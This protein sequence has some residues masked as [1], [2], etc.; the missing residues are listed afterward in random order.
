M[1]QL[2]RTHTLHA[3]LA[4]GLIKRMMQQGD[5]AVL[6]TVLSG[7]ML[8]SMVQTSLMYQLTQLP[9]RER[10]ARPRATPIQ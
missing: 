4:N 6:R 5:M 8:E 10:V 3:L 2:V 7:G 1:T 9:P